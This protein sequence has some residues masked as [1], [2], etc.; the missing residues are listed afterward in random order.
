MLHHA[1]SVISTAH[2][3]LRVEV[4]ILIKFGTLLQACFKPLMGTNY[5]YMTVF[6]KADY[7]I[8]FGLKLNGSEPL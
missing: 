5:P 8:S 6:T 3:E 7:L 1:S 2:Y 4:L